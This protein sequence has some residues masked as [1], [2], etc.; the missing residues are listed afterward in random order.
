MPAGA[1]AD[2]AP[3]LGMVGPNAESGEGVALAAAGEGVAAPGGEAPLPPQEAATNAAVKHERPIRAALS[4]FTDAFP[5]V[6]LTRQEIHR[7]SRHEVRRPRSHQEE[8]VL[9]RGESSGS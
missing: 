5:L 7:R 2:G 3:G 9:R 4:T 1:S 6:T 8:A